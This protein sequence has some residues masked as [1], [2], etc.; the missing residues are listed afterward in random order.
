IWNLAEERFFGAI[1]TSSS[2]F[3]VSPDGTKLAAE[4][5]ASTYSYTTVIAVLDRA[6]LRRLCELRRPSGQFAGSAWFRV[7]GFDTSSKKLFPPRNTELQVWDANS[8]L[9]LRSLKTTTPI[10]DNPVSFSANGRCIAVNTPQSGMLDTES[11]TVT[12]IYASREE[13]AVYLG[14]PP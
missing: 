4:V 8:G 6:S 13:L 11:E 14:K 12:R 2:H 1:A 3:A 5:P 10:G 9:M 7:C